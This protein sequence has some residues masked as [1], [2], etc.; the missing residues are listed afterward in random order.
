MRTWTEASATAWLN[1]FTPSRI[2][3]KLVIVIKNKGGLKGLKGCSA[4][5]YLTG[6]CGYRAAYITA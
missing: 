3:N 2:E 5:S 6:H 4:L 1:K